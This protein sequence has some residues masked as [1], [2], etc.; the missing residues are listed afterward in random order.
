MI[1]RMSGSLFSG[2]QYI[3]QILCQGLIRYI[4]KGSDVSNWYYYS[5]SC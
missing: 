4:I 3:A 1:I 2:V 5:Y